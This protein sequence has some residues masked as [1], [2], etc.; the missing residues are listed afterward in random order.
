MRLAVKNVYK[1]SIT[2]AN[3]VQFRY[4]QQSASLPGTVNA[5]K[6]KG[7][8]SSPR[9]DRKLKCSPSDLG[10]YNRTRLGASLRG[11]FHRH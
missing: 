5:E 8:F 2:N 1:F 7:E 10:M 6:H 9:S 3:V 11:Q 4:R